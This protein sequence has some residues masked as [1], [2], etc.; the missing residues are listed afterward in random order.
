VQVDPPWRVAIISQILAVA[1]G[2]TE[3]V[4]ALGHEPVGLLF[5]RQGLGNRPRPPRAREFL[6]NLLLD[7]PAELDLVVPHE[8]GRVAPLL[9]ALEPDLVLC[10][11]FGWRLP[12]EALSVPRLGIVNAHPSLLP[13]YRGPHPIAWAVQQGETE[14]GLSF[15]RMDEHFDTGPIL[16]QAPVALDD[17]ETWETLE[18]KMAAA[19]A[20]LAPRVFER[21]A[22][23][24]PGDPQPA[25]QASYHSMFGGEG[26]VEIDWT[27]SAREIHNLVRAWRFVAFTRGERGPLTELAGERVR[28]LRTRREPGEGTRVECGDGPLWVVETEAAEPG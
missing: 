19:S 21:L 3:L 8:R 6:A 11:G 4:R 22:K 9:R 28:V 1:N 27:R 16:A 10:L 7:A 12:A 13:R 24:D 26:L 18:Q 23:G 17:E 14:I 25:E 20:A 5:Q 2:F 15:H